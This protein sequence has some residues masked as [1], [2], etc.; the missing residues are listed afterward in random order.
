MPVL[1]ATVSF[2]T[3]SAPPIPYTKLRLRCRECDDQYGI[4]SIRDKT[5]EHL[6]PK[7]HRPLLVG[8]S[9]AN[10]M[11]MLMQHCTCGYLLLGMII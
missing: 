11:H 6:Y 5:G 8:A 7:L 2:G 1:G 9:N 10:Y 3:G 4:C